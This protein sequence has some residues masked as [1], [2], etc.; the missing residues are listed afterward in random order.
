V[1]RAHA[2]QAR[3]AV[4]R[5][6]PDADD[7][8]ARAVRYLIAQLD[9]LQG[10]SSAATAAELDA[11]WARAKQRQDTPTARWQAAEA[12]LFAAWC[13]QQLGADDDA[14]SRA[15]LADA[16]KVLRGSPLADPFLKRLATR[17]LSGAASRTKP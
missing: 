7:A 9:V 17:A 6:A 13:R 12:A 11:A 14:S 15:Q 3:D 8:S 5:I 4:M 1:A 2:G 10:R 16:A